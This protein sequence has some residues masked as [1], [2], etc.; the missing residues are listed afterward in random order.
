MNF[1]N[2]GDSRVRQAY[3]IARAAHSGQVDKAG[4]DYLNHP[5]AVASN[6]GEDISAIIIALL[7]DVV[8]DAGLTFD[9]LEKNV[10]LTAEEISAL[11]LLTHD[12]NIPYA[13][14]IEKIKTNKLAAKVKI[15]DLKHNSDLSR[16]PNVTEKDLQRVEKYKAAL[17]KLIAALS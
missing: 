2:H 6:V 14:Y 17:I 3:K 7:H 8:E 4:V 13:D 10:P 16:L 11:K 15:A 9:Y 1:E 5:V 12:K